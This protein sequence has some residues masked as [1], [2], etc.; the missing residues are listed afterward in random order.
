MQPSYYF[1]KLFY[2][3]LNRLLLGRSTLFGWTLEAYSLI[4]WQKFKYESPP[5]VEP[6][7]I[8]D[9]ATLKEVKK[10]K[11]D[12]IGAAVDAESQKDMTDKQISDLEKAIKS[13]G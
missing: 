6:Q 12:E 8:A 3:S 5:Q 2:I 13:K 1:N 4:S 11:D 10:V 7:W 9:Q